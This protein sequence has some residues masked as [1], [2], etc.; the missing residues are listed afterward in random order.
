MRFWSLDWGKRPITAVLYT[1]KGYTRYETTGGKYGL[2]ALEKVEDLKP[3]I[4]T[5]E[6]SEVFGEEVTGA[7]N[8]TMLPIFPLYSGENRDSALDNLKPLIDSY[9]M[10]L[11]GLCNDIRDCAQVYWLI[12]GAMGM[13]EG[14]KRQLLDRL[15]L[16]HMAVVDGENSSITTY[17]H[18]IP[19]QAR[20]AALKQLRNQMYENFG[21]F[22]VHTVE[23]GAT[24][25][26]IE[27]AYWPMDEEADAFE[28]QLITA[29][30]MILDMMGIDDVPIFVRNRVSNQKE[31]TEMILLAAQY[32][33]RQTVLEKLP[34]ISVD[35]IDGILARADGESFGR[36]EDTQTDE[37][38]EDEGGEA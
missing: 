5:V 34:W 8:L 38:E 21:G 23:A 7:G 4:E 28:Y 36:F 12:S 9:D 37:E 11:S 2:S 3:Y 17:T 6:T 22:D 35:E 1:E 15:I 19:Y 10:I 27:A 29:I 26:H 25:D 32:L 30:R 16:Q 14:D 20:E 13:S 31:Q 33:D 24:N 18:E